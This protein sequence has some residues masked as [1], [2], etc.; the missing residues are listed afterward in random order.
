MVSVRTVIDVA[1]VTVLAD[2]PLF[3]DTGWQ[4]LDKCWA[5]ENASVVKKRLRLYGTYKD[6][7]SKIL[8][9]LRWGGPG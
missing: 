5:L 9:M 2:L 4:L 8:Y 7:G 3:H 1:V 6:I